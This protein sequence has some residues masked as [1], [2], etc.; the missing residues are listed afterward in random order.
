MSIPCKKAEICL[1]SFIS[2]NKYLCVLD[3]G[4]SIYHCTAFEHKII[5]CDQL[6]FTLLPSLSFNVPSHEF[7]DLSW[8]RQHTYGLDDGGLSLLSLLSQVAS[9]S[10]DL[11]TRGGQREDEPHPSPTS[12][13]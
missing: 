13:H 5:S 9:L 8:L 1:M 12:T 6:W 3:I 11:D 2:K 4:Y 10:T 7:R